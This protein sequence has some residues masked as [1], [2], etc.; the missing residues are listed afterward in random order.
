M[1]P[2]VEVGRYS[3]NIGESISSSSSS[4]K[5]YHSISRV[6]R[7]AALFGLGIY[8]IRTVQRQIGDLS[9][10]INFKF[11]TRDIIYRRDRPINSRNIAADRSVIYL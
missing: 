10:I 4:N 7:T 1:Q 5:V 9:L 6:S 3:K 8:F 11:V 2:A